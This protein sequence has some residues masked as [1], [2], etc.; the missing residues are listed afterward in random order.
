MT[1]ASAPCWSAW[2][3][4]LRSLESD[5]SSTLPTNARAS[6][7]DRQ[8]DEIQRILDLV[9]QCAGQLAERGKALEPVELGLALSC[10]AQLVDH[11]VEAARE[12]SDLVA[13]MRLRYRFK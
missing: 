3:D 2:I 1:G 4:W 6:L 9:R 12:Q 5:N 11:L 8:A 13:P 7:V 10:A